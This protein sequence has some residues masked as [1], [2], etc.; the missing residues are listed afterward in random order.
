MKHNFLSNI[1]NTLLKLNDVSLLGS[2]LQHEHHTFPLQPDG[3][4]GVTVTASDEFL[5]VKNSISI[6]ISSLRSRGR[7]SLV[8]NWRFFFFISPYLQQWVYIMP[9][10]PPLSE[11]TIARV[12]HSYMIFVPID[13]TIDDV[14]RPAAGIIASV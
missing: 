6:S 11:E 10:P 7:C 14:N 12:V 4:P 1:G 2:A 5:L 9:P 13:T 8:S 3:V